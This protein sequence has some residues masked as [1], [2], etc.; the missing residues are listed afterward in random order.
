MEIKLSFPSPNVVRF[1][2][3]NCGK[4]I[5]I[6]TPMEIPT[7]IVDSKSNRS[8]ET[9][10]VSNSSLTERTV[11]TRRAKSIGVNLTQYRLME[12]LATKPRGATVKQIKAG[13]CSYLTQQVRQGYPGS[14]VEL[15]FIE[16]DVQ[17]SNGR[18]AFLFSLTSKGK[19]A[20]ASTEASDEN[21]GDDGDEY[22]EDD[23]DA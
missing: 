10:Y 20:L 18:D 6:E 8:N 13:G 21:D 23:E 9:V 12:L 2:I 7:T 3:E 14:L 5:A 11:K 4:Q 16:E 15:G 19:A 1:E 17:D 22:D